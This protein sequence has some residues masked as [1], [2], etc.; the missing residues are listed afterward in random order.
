MDGEWETHHKF[1]HEN[2]KLLAE[3]E[4]LENRARRRDI[5][6]D[7]EALFDFYDRRIGPEVVSGRHFD[8]WWKKV[9]RDEPDLLNFEKSMLI[10]DPA[11][12]VSAQDYPDTWRHGELALHLSYQFEPGADA[13]GV[14]VHIPLAVLNQVGAQGFDWQVPGLRKD[15]VAALIRSLPKVWRR[16]FVP[17]PDVAAAVVA[18]IDPS[19]GELVAAVEDELARLTGIRVPVDAWD[20]SK[21]PDHLRVTFRVVDRKRTVAEGKDLNVLKERLRKRMREEMSGGTDSPERAGLRTFEAVPKVYER[22]RGGHV[23]KAFPA[24]TD[25]RDSVAVRLYDTEAEQQRAMAEG[26]PGGW[27]C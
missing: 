3:V 7:D 23:V 19:D 6:V 18:A 14:T 5:L 9:R 11:K 4:D 2:R 22:R 24:L 20:L 17:A 15:V 21:V 12:L 27:C 1:F 13:D 8:S 25:E 10:N 26:T 16:N